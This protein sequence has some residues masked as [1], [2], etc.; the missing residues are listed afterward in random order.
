MITSRSSPELRSIPEGEPPSP[1]K[2]NMIFMNG[3]PKTKKIKQ[4]HQLIFINS[5][6]IFGKKPSLINI[7][8]DSNHVSTGKGYFEFEYHNI[9]DIIRRSN[10]YKLDKKHTLL[11]TQC[12]K[13]P[14]LDKYIYL[15]KYG[16]WRRKW[17]EEEL[18]N[19]E[20]GITEATEIESEKHE[21]KDMIIPTKEEYLDYW[22][23]LNDIITKS[24]YSSPSISGDLLQRVESHD[25][26]YE[27]V[28]RKHTYTCDNPLCRGIYHRK[29]AE[30][31]GAS[32]KYVYPLLPI[33]E[34]T[35]SLIRSPVE[36]DYL[37]NLCVSK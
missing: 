5:E 23:R 27:L 11:T 17:T 34:A 35:E 21:I 16:V 14:S 19:I 30:D 12:K 32:K 33:Y 20:L 2:E 15:E 25:A 24:G 29:N 1:L 8:E 37:C 18:D 28:K 7:Y 31:G 10:G 22:S 6:K 3:L 26:I 4:L 36:Y 13:C 9:K